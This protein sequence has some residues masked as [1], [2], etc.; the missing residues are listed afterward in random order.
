M[1]GLLLQLIEETAII[2]T[3]A[4][5]MTRLKIFRLT[6]QQVPDQRAK[7]LM[8]A[9]FGFLDFLSSYTGVVVH[10]ENIPE[11]FS[12]TPNDLSI[13]NTRPTGIV[14]GG[15]MGG[16]LVGLTIGF[17]TAIPRV[18]NGEFTSM[19]TLSAY[20]LSGFLA[21]AIGRHF[22]RDGR[23]RP[24]HAVLLGAFVEVIHMSFV[25][26]FSRPHALAHEM[27]ELIAIPLI[28]INALGSWVFTMIF[29]NVLDEEEKTRAFQIRSSFLIADKT[30]PYFRKGL[31]EQS[32]REAAKII[33]EFSEADAISIT[34]QTHVIA[35][36]GA[37][38]DHHFSPDQLITKMTE[39]VLQKGERVIAR[40]PQEIS[41]HDPQCP[42]QA[43]IALPLFVREETVG[44]LIL[45][46]SKINRL[47]SVDEELAEGI[48]KL[49]STQLELGEIERQANLLR[50]AEIKAL[51]AQVNPHFLFNAINTI[52]A[53]CRTDVMLARQLL[54]NLSTYFRSN[55]QGAR[56]MLIPLA[57]EIEHVHAFMSLEQARFPGRYTLKMKLEPGLER[58][59]IPPF[60][61]Q[62]LVENAIGHGLAKRKEEA[63]VEIDIKRHSRHIE[64][65]VRDNGGGIPEEKLHLLGKQTIPSVKGTGTALQ[66]IRERL[67]GI[68]G[69]EA[70]MS[71][72]SEPYQ[73]TF[74]QL[75]IPISVEG[76][77]V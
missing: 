11:G 47:G 61:L 16:P 12:L 32:S 71:I 43:A 42:L 2:V 60:V 14:I 49:I 76:E 26:L 15:L 70:S 72:E 59:S 8:I 24:Y 30:L 52:V 55:L 7:I 73:G 5:V 33:Q 58:V 10:Q 63:L 21:G 51:Q 22:R 13:A 35:H 54:L 23:I 19:A 64:I 36:V 25:F 48:S 17:I 6:F 28:L 77:S 62:P 65:T 4:F 56:Q 38:E 1:W 68:Y 74:V 44:S 67:K 20:L 37:G 34:D 9:V 3:I 18:L 40:T 66:N 45:Y 39:Q 69:P 41:C 75:K 46:F 53:I 29:E 57:K 50:D 27:I 31:N